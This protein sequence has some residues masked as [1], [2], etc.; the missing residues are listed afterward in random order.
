MEEHLDLSHTCCPVCKNPSL[1]QTLKIVTLNQLYPRAITCRQCGKYFSVLYGVPYLGSFYE[2]EIMSLIEIAAVSDQYAI[3]KHIREGEAELR[4]WIQIIDEYFQNQE[5]L[6]ILH[7]YGIKEKPSW[8]DNRLNEHIAFT[9][10]TSLV[11]VQGK[12]ILD[13]AAGYGYDSLK[14]HIAG[15][16]VTSLEYNPLLC[17]IGRRNLPD[18]RWVGGSAY[19]LPFEN[20]SFDIIVSNAALHHLLDIPRALQEMLRVVK[21]GGYVLNLSESFSDDNLTEERH[22]EM[23]N[24]TTSVLS[25]INEQSPAFNSF[26][27]IFQLYEKDLDIRIFTDKISEGNRHFHAWSLSEAVKYLSAKSGSI[28]AIITRKNKTMP[29][30]SSPSNE[31]EL[32]SPEKFT[33]ALQNQSKALRALVDHIPKKYVDLPLLSFQHPRFYLLNGWKMIKKGDENRIAYKRGRLFFSADKFKKPYLNIAVLIPYTDKSDE[34]RISVRINSRKIFSKKL[35]RGIWNELW[36][37]TSYAIRSGKIASLEICLDTLLDSDDSKLFHVKKIRFTGRK[38]LSKKQTK[39]EHFGITTLCSCPWA[40]KDSII[41]LV[42]SDTDHAL[43]IIHRLHAFGKKIRMIV[44]ERQKEF[45]DIFPHVIVRNVYSD[46]FLNKQL[47]LSQDKGIEID[48]FVSESLASAKNLYRMVCETVNIKKEPYVLL[49]GGHAVR[50]DRPFISGDITE[51]FQTACVLF[52]NGQRSNS[53]PYFKR[54]ITSNNAEPAQ[55]IE[56]FFHLGA[57]AREEEDGEWKQFYA[58]GI[59]LLKKPRISA[60][61]DELYRI[62]S[63][64][65]EIGRI[66]DAMRWF[67]EITE[68]SREPKFTG[69]AFFHL[70][71]IYLKMNRDDDAR[72]AF[73]HSLIHIPTHKK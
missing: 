30:S 2:S 26:F 16:H 23:F 49:P 32:I 67:L 42:S 54:V 35:L 24:N 1:E 71:E 61:P 70:G 15:G 63:L 28:L 3:P 65:K 64:S 19:S 72:K 18:L 39:L 68:S 56:A 51:D 47:F 4:K 62:A 41:L 69:G 34:P 10:A 29:I 45:Y 11:P 33:H 6:Q 66:D 73:L 44:P 12:N 40:R 59:D 53:K 14:Y 46:S 7:K 8:F 60:S 57:I 55:K 27:Q 13:V 43:N 50:C 58:R 5:P 22:A 37:P 38:N 20:E 52:K 21:S 31:K 48:A 9:L 36:I 25:G 17:A